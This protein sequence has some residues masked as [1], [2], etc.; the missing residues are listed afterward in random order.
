MAAPSTKV[1][2]KQVTTAIKNSSSDNKDLVIIKKICDDNK[3]TFYTILKNY[4]K[5]C[6][7]KTTSSKG[8]IRSISPAKT[9]IQVKAKPL[10][11]TNFIES[12]I[13]INFESKTGEI[14][15]EFDID[16]FEEIAQQF[17][18]V[19]LETY[20]KLSDDDKESICIQKNIKELYHHL[21]T[22]N[23]KPPQIKAILTRVAN[24]IN[25]KID[26][27]DIPLASPKT[28]KTDSVSDSSK[29]KPKSK[30]SSEDKAPKRKGLNKLRS[31][32]SYIMK[33]GYFSG[34]PDISERD[35]SNIKKFIEAIPGDNIVKMTNIWKGLSPDQ[36]AEIDSF[37]ASFPDIDSS[38][39]TA[40]TKIASK[41]FLENGNK[42]I[43]LFISIFMPDLSKDETESV[44]T[45]SV[46]ETKQKSKISVKHTDDVAKATAP[47][48][49]P[50][51]VPKNKNKKEVA[52]EPP[53]EINKTKES[54]FV[55]ARPS[56][57]EEA[58]AES[59][60][61]AEAESEA[62]SEAENDEE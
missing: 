56:D 30:D 53:K 60:D 40:K 19:T 29:K 55:K 33:D 58:E 5:Y 16:E 42:A 8:S 50:V 20:S 18:G 25:I 24:S 54:P 28:K 32:Q 36:K 22:L 51:P 39:K 35:V 11:M 41:F 3:H 7:E 21:K 26:L 34:I 59:E 2:C 38:D 1:F 23:F 62:E 17:P 4:K 43:E 49:V 47:V 46:K 15:I 61:E 27:D 48:S 9:T 37:Y 31:F 45:Q 14:S 12:Q 13:G 44:V 57:D 6:I 10:T 52:S